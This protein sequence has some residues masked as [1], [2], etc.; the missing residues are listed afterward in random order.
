M[1]LIGKS[2]LARHLDKWAPQMNLLPRELKTPHEQITV[3]AG[4]EHESELPREVI[5]CQA[6]YGFQLCGSYDPGSLGVQEFASAGDG[7][8]VDA[9]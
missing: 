3:R 8:D 2:R 1:R 5:A 9:A 6:A 7:P 4:P